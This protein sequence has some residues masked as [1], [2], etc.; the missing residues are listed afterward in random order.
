MNFLS[1]SQLAN[2]SATNTRRS[3]IAFGSGSAGLSG[4][5]YQDICF[6]MS[7]MPTVPFTRCRLRIRNSNVWGNT[8][9]SQSVVCT[10][11]YW[12]TP[13]L[14]GTAW[15]GDFTGAPTSLGI[16]FTQ[17]LATEYVSSWF[18][19]PTVTPG[20]AF[21]LSFGFTIA[22][23][24]TVNTD[25]GPGFVWH[26]VTSTG[27]AAA[28]G[29]AAAPGVGAAVYGQTVFDI[30]MEYEYVG[31]NPIGLVLG[32]SLSAGYLGSG[33]ATWLS[34]PLGAMGTMARWPELLGNRLGHQIINGGVPGAGANT[35]FIN[36]ANLPWSRFDLGPSINSGV[37]CTP[38]YAIIEVTGIND[39]TN[40]TVA[41]VQASIATLVSNCQTAGIN[42]VYVCTIPP[43]YS[44]ALSYLQGSTAAVLKTTIS[45]GSLSTV[46]GVGP[47]LTTTAQ[48]GPTQTP[49]KL[50]DWYN[51]GQVFT[52]ASVTT[53]SG[54][55]TVT[56]ASGGFPSVVEPMMI[57]GTGITNGAQVAS[58]SGNT[59][60]MTIAATAS[61]T[62]TLTF[63]DYG[64]WFEN[65]ASRMAEGPYPLS[66]VSGTT[67]L[68]LT[69]A[70]TTAQTHNLGCP[71]Y[72]LPE[73]TRQTLN[74][75]Y[76][77]GVPG[78][79]GTID[80]ASISEA[81]GIPAVPGAA[82]PQVPSATQNW[83]MYPA[84]NGAAGPTIHPNSIGM[85][86]RW[87]REA[88]AAIAGV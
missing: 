65:P 57:T 74:A 26:G 70:G 36:T 21:G 35:T 22:V 48:S 75:W 13:N 84:A 31:D 78:T 66:A 50:G 40:S 29:N 76:R 27:C 46:S 34:A 86:Q 6:R 16:S 37:S 12:G 47:V 20:Q 64:I 45:A 80:F 11:V 56:V 68:T 87:A 4:T 15:A 71:V 59:L 38:D 55:K 5:T 17:D 79:M 81:P 49:G 58:I 33:A 9:T 83:A 60:T 28:A 44:S 41:H 24:N 67:T 7:H 32:T 25:S 2:P 23:D 51:A 42:R 8:T 62:V 19:P 85:Y 39:L 52:V 10:G 77:N 61:G 1:A 73:G 14:T 43:G 63:H 18:T 53:S 30:R 88:V 72:T 69:A 3:T 54:L 82:N